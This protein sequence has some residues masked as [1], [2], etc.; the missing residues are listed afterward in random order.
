MMISV[1]MVCMLSLTGTKVMVY[2]LWWYPR[3][4]DGYHDQHW[5]NRKRYA[6]M[7]CLWTQRPFD[8]NWTHRD[9]GSWRRNIPRAQ[10]IP[11]KKFSP[12]TKM[13][14]PSHKGAPRSLPTMPILESL[15]RVHDGLYSFYRGTVIGG[16]M[17]PR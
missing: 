4:V 10:E 17:L 14:R 15:L 9:S 6:Q 5:S 16:F 3:C 12:E 1:V 2:I 13:T 11:S 8:L 7:H